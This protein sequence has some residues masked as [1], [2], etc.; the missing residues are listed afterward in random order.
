MY[1]FLIEGEI[2]LTERRDFGKGGWLVMTEEIKVEFQCFL[3]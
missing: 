1:I 2:F 3:L